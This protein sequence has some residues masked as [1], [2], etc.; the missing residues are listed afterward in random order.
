M[1]GGGH[2]VEHPVLGDVGDAQPPYV[3][4]ALPGDR[5]ALDLD[6]AGIGLI[7][8]EE[9]LHQLPLAVALDARDA[10]N[11]P[12]AHAEG[13]AAEHLLAVLV[14]VV[15]VGDGKHRVGGGGRLLFDLEHHVAPHHEAGDILLGHIGGVEDAI[16]LPARMMVSRSVICLIS[17]SLWEMKMIVWPCS[18]K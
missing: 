11:L 7:H 9:H 14:L 8:V 4:L 1:P 6:R 18:L 3:S 5:A 17:L 15:H 13:D 2:A 12:F 16:D 10:E